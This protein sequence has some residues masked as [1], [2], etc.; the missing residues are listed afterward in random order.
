MSANPTRMRDTHT[1]GRSTDES[2]RTGPWWWVST[3]VTW[4]LLIITT[5][6]VLAL[7]VV[8]FLGSAQPYTVLTESMRPT[9]PPGT[10]VVARDGDMNR[11]ATGEVVTY[12][13]RSGEPEVVTH[14]IIA[15]GMNSDGTRT[16][17]TKGD[18]NPRADAAPVKP[19][20]IRGT[21][22]YSIPYLGYVNNWLTGD[23]RVLVVSVLA[24]ALGVYAL[25][26]LIGAVVEV[27]RARARPNP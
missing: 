20:Q 24:G 13:L 22:W 9:Y 7:I 18:N 14:R 3:I 16:Y 10:L 15:S 23:T 25:F 1:A 6:F 21:V 4:M 27:R 11:L 5:A 26:Q 12:Q 2:E 17:I 8:P 19:E